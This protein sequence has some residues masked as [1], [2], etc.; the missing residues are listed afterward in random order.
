LGLGMLWQAKANVNRTI[1]ADHVRIAVH[2]YST[3]ELDSS[4]CFNRASPS[5]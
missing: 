1:A 4:N 3:C 2:T 5:S